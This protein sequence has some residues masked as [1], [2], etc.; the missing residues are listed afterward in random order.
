MMAPGA[1]RVPVGTQAAAALRSQ[2]FAFPRQV[3][4]LWV[5]T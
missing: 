3:T 4:F 5:A 2:A 1:G